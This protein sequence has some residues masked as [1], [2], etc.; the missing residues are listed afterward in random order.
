[1]VANKSQLVSSS[2]LAAWASSRQALGP[3]FDDARKHVLAASKLVGQLF[4]L[5]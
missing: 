5:T 4:D 2:H 3:T 1:M